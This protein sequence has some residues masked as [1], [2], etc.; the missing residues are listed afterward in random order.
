MLRSDRRLAAQEVREDLQHTLDALHLGLPILGVS[1]TEVRPPVEVAADF[2]A[3]QSAEGR[4]DDRV[5]GARTYEAVQ[6]TTTA[7]RREALREAARA[8]AGRIL[9]AARAETDQFLALL[10]EVRR[11]RDLSL[12]RLYIE[13]VQSMLE[14]VRRKLVLPPGDSIDLTILGLHD[15]VGSPAVPR[16]NRGDAP[17]H[18]QGKD[19]P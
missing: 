7:A 6:L 11:S 8:E 13:S 3:A 1:L 17:D 5:N 15:R 4:R 19:G 9:L 10:A 18:E 12:R 16:A 14:R 2:A